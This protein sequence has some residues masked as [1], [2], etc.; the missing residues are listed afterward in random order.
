MNELELCICAANAFARD[1]Q[2]V[3]VYS[4][5]RKQVE[6]LAREFRRMH[7]QGYLNDVR[8]PP[9]EHLAVAKAIG[10]EWLGM[11]HPALRALEA[12]VGTHH[13]ALPRPFLNAVEE[14]L[15]ARRLSVVVASPTL[16][17]G[18]DLPCSTLIFRSLKRYEHGEWVAISPAEFANVIG[19]AGRAYVDLDGIIVLPTFEGRSREREHKLFAELISLSRGQRLR[20]GLA[21]LV[22]KVA[23]EIARRLSV[24]W[25]VLFE[26]VANH[27]DLWADVRLATEAGGEGLDESEVNLE[28]Y[29]G[30]LDVALFSL[31]EPLDTPMKDLATLLDRVLNDSLWKRTLAH[32]EERVRQL[33]REILRSRAEWLWGA[34][35]PK[36]REACFY[37]GLGRK[38]GLFLNNQLDVLVDVLCRF[39]AAIATD[40]EDDA[41]EAAVALGELVTQESFFAVRGPKNWQGVLASWVKGT[42]FADIL[43]GRGTLDAQRAQAFVQEGV[44]FRLVWA[45]EA[46]RV[47]A[48]STNHRRVD[49]LGDG[50]AFALT[51]GVPAIPAALLC[52]M[53]FSSRVGAIWVA[54]QLSATF[55]DMDG[56]RNWLRE[57]DASLSNPDFWPSETHYLLWKQTSVPTTS[58]YPRPWNHATH[59]VPVSWEVAALPTSGS[60][61]RVI[62]GNG[63]T[64]TICDKDLA[65][66][67]VAQLPFDPHGAALRGKVTASR[68]LHIAY[69]GRS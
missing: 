7:D 13:G 43:S 57:H 42:A 50:P 44:V 16:A 37:S 52:Q 54:R 9:A 45:A 38:A 66:L 68:E 40:N 15:D 36:Q 31:I 55:A 59:T 56:L 63:R 62:P 14:L 19:R 46:V 23:A 17:Q 61:V 22:W 69:F 35:T 41:A 30:D 24:S 58:E 33:E 4:P 51:Y 25:D 34:T 29:V 49:E 3:L 12:G 21:L 65:P 64:A 47:Q 6:P 5:Q 48:I 11:K 26:Y 53:G 67:G 1:G 60:V 28:E 18:I 32:E 27:R 20:S 39:Q 2:T 8:I 10:R